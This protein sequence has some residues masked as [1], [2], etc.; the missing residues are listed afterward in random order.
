MIAVEQ[1]AE[2]DAVVGAQN[3]VGA[4]LID[5]PDD[6]VGVP[7]GGDA[8]GGAGVVVGGGALRDGRY[9]DHT[10]GETEGF[11][12]VAG[13]VIVN[14]A[15]PESGVAPS[16]SAEA[17]G[18]EHAVGR[19]VMTAHVVTIDDVDQTLLA[20]ADQEMR[21]SAGLIGED[22][23]AAGTEVFVGIGQVLFIKRSERVGNV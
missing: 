17:G 2:I 11:E 18:A 21:M 4:I 13:G 9:G 19:A 12:D 6:A 3:G 8:W 22:H 14:Q 10:I 16:S 23:G 1:L 20:A 15:I 5:V 7:V